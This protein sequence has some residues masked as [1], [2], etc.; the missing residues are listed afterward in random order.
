MIK[1]DFPRGSEKT[2]QNLLQLRKL[3]KIAGMTAEQ[4][5][6]YKQSGLGGEER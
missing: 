3:M 2:I 5:P 1:R 6:L 4:D